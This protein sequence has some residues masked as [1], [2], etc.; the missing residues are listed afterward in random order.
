[1]L[2][3]DRVFTPISPP[4]STSIKYPFPNAKIEPPLTSE[5]IAIMIIKIRLKSGLKL[6]ILIG[7]SKVDWITIKSRDRKIKNMTVIAL[8]I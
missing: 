6:P 4:D 2:S 7:A 5:S 3:L 1:M 8:F